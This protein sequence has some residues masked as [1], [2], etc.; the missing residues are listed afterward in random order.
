MR[1]LIRLIA[2]ATCCLPLVACTSHGVEMVNKT[3]RT[4]T[5]EC[6]H[7]QKDGALTAPY[8]TSVLVP[9]GQIKLHPAGGDGF[10]GERVRVLVADAPETPGHSILLHIPSTKTRDFDVEYIAG[11]LYIREFKKGR[12]WSE[13]GDPAF[14]K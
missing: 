2:C 8:A 4:L 1:T 11:R 14:G 12:D 3:G 13:T 6:L 10:A 9:E 5:V 7:V